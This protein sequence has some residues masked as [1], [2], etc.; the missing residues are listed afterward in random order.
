MT[1]LALHPGLAHDLIDAE[2]LAHYPLARPGTTALGLAE[3]LRWPRA[4]RIIR[5]AARINS[6]KAA[7]SAARMLRDAILPVVLR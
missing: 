5:Q 7:G 2:V 6:N 3:A 4:E 1:V